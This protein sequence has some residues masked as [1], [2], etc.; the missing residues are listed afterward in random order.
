[1]ARSLEG[2]ER[3]REYDRNPSVEQKAR[4]AE[5]Q[6]RINAE[7][8]D[9][10][11]EYHMRRFGITAAIYD[12]MLADQNGVCAICFDPPAVKRLHV[13]HD[14]SC[15]AGN[16]SCGRCIRGLLCFE[17]NTGIGKFGDNSATVAS[18]LAYLRKGD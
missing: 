9:R 16:K 5:Y 13:D 17:C 15:C 4:K 7:N 8:P 11:R 3:R 18:A 2:M 10:A 12:K 1:M 6:R 14:H